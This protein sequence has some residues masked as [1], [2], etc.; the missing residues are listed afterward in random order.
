MYLKLEKALRT[1]KPTTGPNMKPAIKTG[2]CIGK[3]VGPKALVIWN[4]C[5]KQIAAVTSNAI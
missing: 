3:N 4:S 5:G 1:V 2:I